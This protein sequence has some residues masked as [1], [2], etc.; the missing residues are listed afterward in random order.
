VDLVVLVR[1]DRELLLDHVSVL[2]H[3]V[4]S[5]VVFLFLFTLY[6]PHFLAVQSFLA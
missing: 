3:L 6:L 2:D 1:Q 4:D 5:P